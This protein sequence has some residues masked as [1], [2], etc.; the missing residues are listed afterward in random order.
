MMQINREIESLMVKFFSGEITAEEKQVLL[1]WVRESEKHRKIYQE[2]RNVWQIAHPAFQASDLSV[3]EVEI[4]LLKKMK[5]SNKVISLLSWQRI[6]IMTILPLF[7]LSICLYLYVPKSQKAPIRYQE[8]FVPAGTYS[9]VDLPDGSKVWLNSS[10]SLKYPLKFISG[11]KTHVY[12]Q[13]EAYFEIKSDK[14]APFII[15]TDHKEIKATNARFNVEAY[16]M[17]TVS[18]ITV[19]DGKLS[20]LLEDAR[21]LSLIS[22]ERFIYNDKSLSYQM[23]KT[24]SSKWYAWKDGKMIF[25]NDPLF[26]VFKRMEH[27]FHVDIVLNDSAIGNRL[28]QVT[29]ENESLSDILDTLKYIAFISYKVDEL[30]QLA[31]K[32]YERRIEIY[33]SDKQ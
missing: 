23:V 28:C 20:V 4:S 7:I 17:D 31:D 10:S 19:A 18:Y 12:L 21:R 16:Q 13:G 32:S 1:S 9:I 33:S 29:F 5:K 15:H 6:A 14:N 2:Y 22:G 27:K 3:D 11:S 25:D 24:E 8:I 26:Y 30:T